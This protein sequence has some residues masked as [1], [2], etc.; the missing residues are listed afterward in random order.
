MSGKTCHWLQLVADIASESSVRIGASSY[1]ALF[2]EHFPGRDLT[3]F[4]KPE[5]P[6]R[7][8]KGDTKKS[9]GAEDDDDFSDDESDEE[10]KAAACRAEAA[11]AWEASKRSLTPEIVRSELEAIKT[12]ATGA[13]RAMK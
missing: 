6:P 8:G 5:I 4:I 2:V 3:H 11:T 9:T 7:A 1:S 10:D 13:L 12:F